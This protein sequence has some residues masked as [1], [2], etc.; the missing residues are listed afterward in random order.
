MVGPKVEK[1]DKKGVRYHAKEKVTPDGIH[2]E[3][4]KKAVSLRPTSMLL[5][6]VLIAKVDDVGR[7][8][9]VLRQAPVKDGTKDWNCVTW[10]KD[11]LELVGKDRR[12]LGRSVIAWDTVRKTAMDYCNQKKVAGRF[13]S[14][15]Y[16]SEKVPTYDLLERK[17]TI[18]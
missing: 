2:W 8:D 15:E 1:H 5:V 9:T 17:E 3:F 14:A 7:L 12:A 16:D 4:E 11:A 6:R 18:A 10:L 13:S